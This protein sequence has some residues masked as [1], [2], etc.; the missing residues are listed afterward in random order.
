MSVMVRAQENFDVG[1][2]LQKQHLTMRSTTNC[3]IN[4][5]DEDL[6]PT[7]SIH[8]IVD[9]PDKLINGSCLTKSTLDELTMS[10]LDKQTHLT[11][12]NLMA[13]MKHNNTDDTHQPL[14][15]GSLND[16][17]DTDNTKDQGKDNKKKPYGGRPLRFQCPDCDRKFHAPSHLKRHRLCHTSE[18]PFQCHICKKG[19]LQAWHL[20]R[21]MTIHTGNK[22]F[23][24]PEC[25]KTF[26][27]RFEMKTHCNYIH[28]GIKEHECTVCNKMFTLRSNL[29]VHMRKHTGEKPYQCEICLKRFGQRGHLQYH[30][31]KHEG[32]TPST[33]TGKEHSVIKANEFITKSKSME[34]DEKDLTTSSDYGSESDSMNSDPASPMSP[35]FPSMTTPVSRARY[36]PLSPVSRPIPMSRSP[37]NPPSPPESSFFRFAGNDIPLSGRMFDHTNPTEIKPFVCVS[38]NCGFGEIRSIRA[39]VRHSHARNSIHNELFS[40]AFCCKTFTTIDSLQHHHDACKQRHIPLSTLPTPPLLKKE[41][42]DYDYNPRPLKRSGSSEIYFQYGKRQMYGPVSPGGRSSTS[43]TTFDRLLPPYNREPALY[44]CPH[45]CECRKPPTNLNN[46]MVQARY[47]KYLEQCQQMLESHVQLMEAIK[48]SRK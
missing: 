17:S 30:M 20:G 29:K 23:Q 41:H 32:K 7:A 11:K 13:D 24:C 46:K 38:C 19:F 15:K 44:E 14:V 9:T 4:L 47:I 6:K 12:A 31:R 25:P 26:G 18:R 16:N 42:I 39:H 8:V 34:E 43:D 36:S 22:P 2:Y 5:N 3:T 28:K 37:Y 10:N 48:V 40:C 45:G 1:V 21:H 35:T 33:P 27:S